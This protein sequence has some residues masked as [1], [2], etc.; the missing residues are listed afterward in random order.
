MFKR[1]TE[2]RNALFVDGWK[3]WSKDANQDGVLSWFTDLSEKLASLSAKHNPASA[4]L[5]R[6]L[7]QPN[8]PIQGSTADRNLDIGCVSDVGAGMNTRCQWSQILVP[9]ELQI[10]R[11]L[12]FLFFFRATK[13]TR[14]YL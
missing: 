10:G 14:P 9:G 2:D 4:R 7:A 3:G 8:K 6:P 5:R 11:T 12:V 1:C 13:M